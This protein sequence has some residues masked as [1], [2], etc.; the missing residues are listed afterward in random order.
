MTKGSYVV[1]QYSKGSKY[2]ADKL[3]WKKL[4]YDL[5]IKKISCE[6]VLRLRIAL[7]LFVSRGK[8]KI[9]CLYDRKGLVHFSFL[10]PYCLKFSFMNK[11]DY[12]IGPCWTREDHR[13]Q[14]LYG[15][16]LLHIARDVIS[17]NKSSNVYVL[18]REANIESTRG[19]EKV[20]FMKIGVC[21]KTK[22]L[23]HYKS[24]TESEK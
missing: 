23:K 22:Y 17:N 15:K 9:Y 1:Y 19:I 3:D 13:G 4:G 7:F 6:K 21:K 10:I 2:S 16:M 12:Q 5:K 11:A 8:Y 20:N 14:G 18:V 24:V